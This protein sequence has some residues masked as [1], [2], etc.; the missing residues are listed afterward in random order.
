MQNHTRGIQR[1]CEVSDDFSGRNQ[2]RIS[3]PVELFDRR[4]QAMVVLKLA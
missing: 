3:A 2:R 1:G 4:Q